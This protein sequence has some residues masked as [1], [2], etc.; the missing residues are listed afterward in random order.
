MLQFTS[1]TPAKVTSVCSKH[2]ELPKTRLAFREIVDETRVSI[3]TYREV[4]REAMF[5]QLRRS[6]RMRGVGGYSQTVPS[7]ILKF[8]PP[9]HN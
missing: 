4:G 8:P 7:L 9:V 1:V 3:K 6:W 2:D 5:Q